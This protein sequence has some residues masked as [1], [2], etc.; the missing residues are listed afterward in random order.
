MKSLAWASSLRSAAGIALLVAFLPTSPRLRTQA[1]AP[2]ASQIVHRMVLAESAAWK[3]RQHFLYRKQERSDRTKGHVWEELAVETSDGT[4]ERLLSID[5]KPLSS[6]QDRL[7]E[8]RIANFVRHPGEFRRQTKRRKEE[9]G[10][11]P[12]LLDE[13]GE[14]FVF[15]NQGK[16]GDCTRIAF[17]PN[18]SFQEKTYQDRV[19]HSMSGVM[20]IGTT[21]MRLR[22][23][24]VHLE[25]R[26][27]FGF[28]LL[29]NVRETTH[30]SLVRKEV[31]PGRWEPS[32]VRVHLDG[33]VL[34]VKSISRDV[35]SLQY[36]FQLVPHDLTVAQAAEMVRS[37]GQLSTL[38]V[39]K[40]Q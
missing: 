40:R 10:R 24:D 31:L 16:Q 8:E 32:R 39:Q 30:F 37:E 34:L 15:A 21:D 19:V 5:G 38:A 13:L 25:H 23:L 6:E 26:V 20:W 1:P 7:E 18:P 27:E 12:G 35:D 9:E 14:I 3:H 4:L 28:G 17:R 2:S 36:G 33:S 22:K 11:M 29:G